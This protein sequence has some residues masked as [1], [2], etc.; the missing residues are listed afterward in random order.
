MRS[1]ETN[2]ENKAQISQKKS[3]KL[4]IKQHKAESTMKIQI[5]S[6]SLLGTISNQSWLK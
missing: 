2:E 4:L 6:L 1:K 5:I 3:K